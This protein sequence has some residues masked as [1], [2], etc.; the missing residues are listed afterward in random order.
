[1]KAIRAIN[2]ETQEGSNN[3]N[4][5]FKRGQPRTSS[6]TIRQYLSAVNLS[7]RHGG[8]P[9]NTGLTA[10]ELLLVISLILNLM[11]LRGCSVGFCCWMLKPIRQ[12][13]Y[14]E[15]VWITRYGNRAQL[16][17]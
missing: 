12:N 8:Q 11:F 10:L 1:M 15:H 2:D 17:M 4:K 6:V 3:K 13:T 14:H 7:K 5:K 16:C 9:G